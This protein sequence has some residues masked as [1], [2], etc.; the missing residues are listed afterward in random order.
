MTQNR[1]S[2]SL[3]PG[4]LG[5]LAVLIATSLAAQPAD[6]VLRHTTVYTVNERRTMA[7]AVAVQAGRIVF[8]GNDAGVAPFI[9]PGTKVLDLAGSF[10]YPGFVDAH[11]H[12]PAIGERE[13]AL[14]LEGTRTKAAFLA[15]VESA[16]KTAKPGAWVTGRGWIETFWSPPAFPSRQDL[17]AIAPNNPIL[18][19]RADGHAAIANSIALR[20]AGITGSTKAPAGGA[21][22]LYAAG[23]PT[24]MLIDHAQGLVEDLVPPPDEAAAEVEACCEPETQPN[25]AGFSVI[26]CA[27]P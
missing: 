9:G 16:V 22:N 14:N 20:R 10:V 5:L 19:E 15:K 1:D 17:D 6:L 4:R 3:R 21:I 11:A 24:G 7:Q 27:A 13:M 8:V 26:S 2:R 18:L 23:Q 12:F 25:Q